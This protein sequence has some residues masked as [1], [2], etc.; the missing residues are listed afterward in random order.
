VNHLHQAQ[1]AFNR[2]ASI[3]NKSRFEPHEI[4]GQDKVN[5]NPIMDL[6]VARSEYAA[7][8]VI[9]RQMPDEEKQMLINDKLWGVK[10]TLEGLTLW[11]LGKYEEVFELIDWADNK[12]TDQIFPRDAALLIA[13]PGLMKIDLAYQKI[14]EAKDKDN[15]KKKEVLEDVTNKLVKMNA[16]DK[17]TIWSAVQYIKKARAK[18]NKAHPVNSYLIQT[19]LSAYRNY[20]KAYTSISDSEHISVPDTSMYK[21]EAKYNLQDLQVLITKLKDSANSSKLVNEWGRL[22]NIKPEKRPTE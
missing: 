9:L 7:A 21:K 15:N 2:A 19:Q 13:L 22:C 12:A 10:L 18:V 20:K 11:K 16:V 6:N 5:L 1:Q 14:L 17:P 8:L 4:V 3:D